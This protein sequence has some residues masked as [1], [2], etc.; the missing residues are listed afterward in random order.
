MK[1]I[2]NLVMLSVLIIILCTGCI[3]SSKGTNTTSTSIEPTAIHGGYFA[4]GAISGSIGGQTLTKGNAIFVNLDNTG[5]VRWATQLEDGSEVYSVQNTANGNLLAVGEING[6][7]LFL[8]RVDEKGKILFQKEYGAGSYQ[9]GYSIQETAEGGY[10]VC[11][12]IDLFDGNS[13][14]IWLEKLNQVGDIEWSK[15][16]GSGG[17]A[18]A[19][20]VEGGG[21]IIAGS[22]KVNNSYDNNV[23]FAKLNQVGDIEWEKT[24]PSAGINS[25][26]SI[27]KISGGYVL[28]GGKSSKNARGSD[29][30][31]FQMDSNGNKIMD[32]VFSYPDG[33]VGLSIEPAE[34][35]GYSII[36]FAGRIIKTDSKGELLW[37]K[38][39]GGAVDIANNETVEVCPI[40][41]IGQGYFVALEKQTHEL[42]LH[43]QTGM[44]IMSPLKSQKL[45]FT[46]FSM[47]GDIEWQTSLDLPIK[48]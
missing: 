16:Y 26:H 15:T 33:D 46:K 2:I 10:I 44:P 18:F 12:E 21:Y 14:Q 32:K 35:G 8:S 43:D 20:Q 3:N 5:I 37:E 13:W 45:F 19:I 4:S 40:T 23:W 42:P 41:Q 24:I 38:I 6:G 7:H 48:Q 36:T 11:G 9:R 22:V 34:N 27:L 17:G 30:W 29:V 28:T 47:D 31:L 39:V 1:Y 25:Y